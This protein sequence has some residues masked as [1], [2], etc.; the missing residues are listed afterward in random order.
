MP[1]YDDDTTNDASASERPFPATVRIAGVIWILFGALGLCG[2]LISL[3]M[4]AAAKGGAAPG[5]GANPNPVAP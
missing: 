1:E 4:Q 5:A 3:A 2:N